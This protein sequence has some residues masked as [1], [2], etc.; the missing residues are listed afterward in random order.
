[1]RLCLLGPLE[2]LAGGESFNVGPRQRRMVLAALAVDAGRMLTLETIADRVWGDAQPQRARHTLYAHLVRIRKML[3]QASAAG[4]GSAGIVRRAG[5]YV[6][7]IEEDRV[8]L[9]RFDGLVVRARGPE[10]GPEDQLRLLDEALNLWRGEPLAGLP[11]DWAARIRQG[12]HNRRI[13]AAVAWAEAALLVNA[14]GPAITRLTDLIAEYPLSERLTAVL[15]R[16]MCA[17]GRGTDALDCYGRIRRRLADELGVD[18]SLD[19]QAMHQA[20]LR[21][22]TGGAPVPPDPLWTVAAGRTGPVSAPVTAPAPAAFARPAQLPPDVVGFTGRDAELDQLDTILTHA[23]RQ[24]TAVP[25]VTV[26]GTAGIGKTALAV[27]WAHR[28]AGKFPDGQ[29]YVNLRGFDPSGTAVTPAEAVRGFLDAFDVPPHRIPTTLQGQIGLYRSLLV[30]RQVLILLDNAHDADQVRQLLPGSP[31]CL[32][33]VTSRD[34]LPGLV[35]GSAAH[36]LTLDLF[37]AADSVELLAQRFGESRVAAEPKTVEEIVDHCARLPLALTVVAARAATNPGF[38][39]RVLADQLRDARKSLDAFD[40]GDPVTDVRAAFSWSYQALSDGAARLFRLLGVHPG[41]DITV[42]AAA[43][44]AALSPDRVRPLLSELVR[45]HLVAEHRPGRFTFHDL[46]RAYALELAGVLDDEAYRRAAIRRVLDHY[47]HTAHAVDRLLYPQRERLTPPPLSADGAAAEELPDPRAALRWLSADR[48][49][50]LEMLRHAGDYGFDAQAWHLAWVMADFLDR[51]GHWH[52]W[53]ASQQA[54]LVAAE[55]LGDAMRQ[56]RTHRYL[57]RAYD[58]LGRDGEAL[59]HLRRALDL[60]RGVGDR[61]GQGR[62][63]LNLTEFLE[64]QGRYRQAL[65][66]AERALELFIAEAHQVGQARARNGIGWCHAMLGDHE[67]ALVH[68]TEALAAFQR[69]GDRDGEAAAWDSV[70]YAHH[71]L[72]HHERAIGCY[73]NALRLFREIGDRYHEADVLSHLGR[74]RHAACDVSAAREAWHE[75]LAILN[76]LGHPDAERLRTTMRTLERER[77]G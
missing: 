70:G 13:D 11:G 15:M 4:D 29:L 48:P 28:V 50:L 51:R 65:R 5:G 64:R 24:P 10:Q 68:C 34:R 27:H 57:A 56:A 74:A 22:E 40:D 58:R 20:I 44:L 71:H 61:P 73:T 76:D 43:S 67:R 63:Y 55:R 66:H 53:A 7:E 45:G 49:V 69:I 25:I 36:P 30:G 2:V 72:G 33:L 59:H 12:W 6:L 17:A 8:D 75:A 47:L 16:A 23:D 32:V 21:G 18:P 77:V 35:A 52:D 3:K 38:A 39:L 42:A 60:F 46:L 1:M 62:V 31:G 19:L 14:A 37:S 26:S 41:P 9:R 54:A